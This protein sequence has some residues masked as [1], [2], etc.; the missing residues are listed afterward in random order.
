MRR[1]A[2][3]SGQSRRQQSRTKGVAPAPGL[4]SRSAKHWPAS[5]SSQWTSLITYSRCAALQ[6]RLADLVRQHRAHSPA[7]AQLCRRSEKGN[8]CGEAA[9]YGL[10]PMD[11]PNPL[12]MVQPRTKARATETRRLWP[13]GWNQRTQGSR[14]PAAFYQISSIASAPKQPRT[15]RIDCLPARPHTALWRPWDASGLPSAAGLVRYI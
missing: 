9:T 11:E 8:E 5:A 2:A 12:P 13:L 1:G 4:P 3:T 6:R 10:K 15:P 14:Q 7:A